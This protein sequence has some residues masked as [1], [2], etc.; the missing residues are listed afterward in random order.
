M[1]T[2]PETSNLNDRQSIID[3]LNALLE[4]QGA[5]DEARAKQVRKAVDALRNHG[6]TPATDADAPVA[7]PPAKDGALDAQIDAGMENL[8]ERVNRQ[9]ERRNRDYEKSLQLMQEVETALKANEL[10]HAEQAHHKLLSIM[11]NIP[12]LSEQ[13]WKDIEKRLNRVRPRLRKLESWRHWGTTQVRQELIEQIKQLPGSD[14]PPEQ[15]A[16]RIRAAR[17][18]W[19][20]W[21]SSGDHAGKELWKEF[22]AACE[23]AYK[24]CAEYFRKLKQQRKDNLGQRQALIDS[25]N[26]RFEGT[27]WKDPDWRDIDRFIREARRDFHKIGNVDFKHRKTV[28][29][30]LDEALEKFDQYL[31]HERERSLRVRERLISDIEALASNDNLRESMD[32]LDALKKQWV[33]TVSDKRGVENRLWKRFQQACDGIYQQRDTVRKQHD[34]ERHDN[35]QQ[36]QALIGELSQAAAAADAELL[37][38]AAALSR[39]QDRWTDIGAIPRKEETQLEQRWRTAQQ[40]FRK[41]LAAAQT[42][43]QASELDNLARRAALC[44]QW[45][46]AI[47]SGATVDKDS[48]QAEWDALPALSGALA[49]AMEQRFQQAFTRADDATLAGNL[50]TKQDACLR[51]EVLLELASPPE[52]QSARM[53]YQ[54]K[55]LNAAMKKEL[56]AQDS[57]EDLLQLVLTTGAVPEGAAEAIGQRIEQC[58]AAWTGRSR[59]R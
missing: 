21:D 11:G 31:S 25:L 30:A 40:Q 28:A 55:R 29:K 20:E 26:A 45:E 41:A 10:Q 2:Q 49:S 51:L 53:A 6:D 35:L 19:Q 37:G 39:I 42:R 24:P 13:R 38:N 36:K 15:L 27:D 46:Q 16:K 59:A 5:I 22:D 50:A 7:E 58:L 9:V 56:A 14:M 32:H 3:E 17:E 8:R 54:V 34:A 47:Q 48:A 43:A 44:R 57:V 23:A 33:V 1:N 4:P 12:G 18:Q 52:F